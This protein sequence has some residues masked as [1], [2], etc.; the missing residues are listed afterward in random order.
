[1]R[2]GLPDVLG[3]LC[4]R[5][6]TLREAGIS[7][8]IGVGL[9]IMSTTAVAVWEQAVPADVFKQQTESARQYSQA[10]SGSIAAALLLAIVPAMSEETF[11]RG[12]LQPVFGVFLSSLLFYSDPFTIWFDAGSVDLVRRLAWFCLAQIALSHQRRHNRARPFQFFALSG[13][14]LMC[15][16]VATA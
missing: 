5:M 10:F 15:C 3:R 7:I 11:Y 13:R 2:R 14:N 4:L 12:A 8:A 9:W 16:I 6:P 1:M